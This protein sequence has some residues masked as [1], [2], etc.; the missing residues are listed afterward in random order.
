MAPPAAGDITGLDRFQAL[1]QRC[2]L[3]D[4]PDDSE[5]IHQR[6]IDGYREPHRRYHTLG[7]IKHC[8]LMFDQCKSLASDPDALDYDCRGDGVQDGPRFVDDGPVTVTGPD[9]FELD[10]DN[11]GIGCENDE[12][13]DE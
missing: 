4:A 11:D 6:L 10:G 9:P 12:P 3:P 1:W 2:L 8:L 5:K 13:P 7:H